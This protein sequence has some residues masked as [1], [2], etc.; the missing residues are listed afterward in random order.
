LAA[1]GLPVAAGATIAN[2]QAT[3]AHEY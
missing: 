1:M 2:L 3:W